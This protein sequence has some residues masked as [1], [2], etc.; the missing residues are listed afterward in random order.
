MDYPKLVAKFTLDAV[1]ELLRYA[2]AVPREKLT[3]R[4]AE[5]ARSVLEI[6]QECATLPAALVAWLQ[7]RPQAVPSQEQYASF[8]A[9]AAALTTLEA[10]ENA[11][12]ENT[13]H[14]LQ[15]VQSLSEADLSQTAVAPWG[16][17][18]TLAEGSMLHHWNITYHLGQIA[19]I[20]LLYGDTEYH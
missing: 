17:T 6:L 15:V 18:Y 2:R 11:L 20:Q 4:P 3:W 8:W 9:Q 13:Q 7:E 14:L 19:Y 1:D 10:C 12:R 5:H 16:K